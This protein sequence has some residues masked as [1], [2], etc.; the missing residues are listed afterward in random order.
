MAE[1]Y[2]KTVDLPGDVADLGAYRGGASLILRRLGPDKTLH[3]FDTWTGTPFDDPMCHHRKGEWLASLDECK[4]LVGQDQ[5]TYYH[6]GVFPYSAEGLNGRQFSF[7]Y[8]DP[9]TYQTVRD[10]IAFFWPRLVQGG[11]LFFDDWKWLACAGG[12]KAVREVFQESDIKE[13]P[14]LYSCMV[15]KR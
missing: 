7:V 8:I 4:A 1:Q 5:Q 6:E 9:D 2:L 3:L 14:S 15:E 12:E 10:A 13:F 11:K